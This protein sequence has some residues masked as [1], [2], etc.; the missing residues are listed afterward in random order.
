MRTKDLF[1]LGA[2]GLAGAIAATLLVG[3]KKRKN[4]VK[5]TPP[6]AAPQLNIQNPGDQSEFP[7][8]PETDRNLG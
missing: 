4:E 3:V 6:Q 5:D 8:A 1:A 2:A 7:S